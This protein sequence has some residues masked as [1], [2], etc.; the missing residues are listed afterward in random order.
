MKLIFLE[1]GFRIRIRI[2]SAY[3]ESLDPDDNSDFF[4]CHY[5]NNTNFLYEIEKKNQPLDPDPEPHVFQ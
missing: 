4:Y 2:G 3:L 5:V 1:A